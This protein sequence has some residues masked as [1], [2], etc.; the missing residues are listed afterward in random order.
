MHTLLS[1]TMIILNHLIQP[2]YCILCLNRIASYKTNY[3]CYECIKEQETN[4]PPFCNECGKS[5][6]NNVNHICKISFSKEKEKFQIFYPFKYK[7]SIREALHKLKYEGQLNLVKFLSFRMAQ[8]AKEYIIP[9]NKIDFVTYVPL[10]KKKLKER[11]FN[12]AY[13]LAKAISRYIGIP[14]IENLILR[15]I[16][17]HPQSTLTELDRTINIREAFKINSKCL[18]TITGSHLLL[19]DDII[20]TGSTAKECVKEITKHGG[21]VT[22]LTAAGG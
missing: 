11:E 15:K 16:Y 4:A 19:I 18:D 13:L 10:H 22:V 6:K 12:Q 14:L 2:N 20:T 1:K 5:I 17:T 21:K 8:F 7:K 9:F 3:I